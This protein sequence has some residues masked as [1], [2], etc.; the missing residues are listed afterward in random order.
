[1]KQ[2]LTD[3]SVKTTLAIVATCAFLIA[4]AAAALIF[5]LRR[6]VK[7]G[8]EPANQPLEAFSEYHNE[9]NVF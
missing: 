6:K 7:P 9:D 3:P 4:G 2:L 5:R 1:M 8:E